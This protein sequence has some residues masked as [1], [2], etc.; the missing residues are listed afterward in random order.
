MLQGLRIDSI[1]NITVPK[2]LK[3]FFWGEVC[4]EKEK[5]ELQWNPGVLIINTIWSS[6]KHNLLYVCNLC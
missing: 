4:K 2:F 6:L 3:L 1:Q 5:P